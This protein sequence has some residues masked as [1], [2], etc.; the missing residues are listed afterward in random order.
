MYTNILHKRRISSIDP[1]Y[2][3]GSKVPLQVPTER[4]NEGASKKS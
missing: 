3:R 4:Q 2:E 1:F